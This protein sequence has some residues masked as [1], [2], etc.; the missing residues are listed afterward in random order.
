MTTSREILERVI[1]VLEEREANYDHPHDNF[2][3]IAD[4]DAVIL[5]HSVTPV[6]VAM[7]SI[8]QKIG[9]LV[10][11]MRNGKDLSD[12]FIDIIGYAVCAYR[13]WEHTKEQPKT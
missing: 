9:R 11:A 1:I 2:Q 10:W 12:H 6:E 4:L 13:C 7:L 3:R 5:G 8:A